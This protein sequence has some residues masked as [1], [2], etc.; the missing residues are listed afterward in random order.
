MWLTHVIEK[1]RIIFGP[2]QAPC[3]LNQNKK[4]CQG[5]R[6]ATHDPKYKRELTTLPLWRLFGVLLGTLW[7]TFQELENSL[8]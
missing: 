2:S 7:G 6:K 8:L 5:K 1:S 4:A 3:K